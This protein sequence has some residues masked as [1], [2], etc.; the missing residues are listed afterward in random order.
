MT[1][2]AHCGGKFGA[3]SGDRIVRIGRVIAGRT[4]A[5]LALNAGKLR[6]CNLAGESRRQ[7]VPHRVAGQTT[8]ILVLMGLL[9]RFE[10]AP[11][12]RIRHRVVNLAV[13]LCAGLSAD[14]LRR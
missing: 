12:P 8:G 6:G 11:M 14:V 9:E 4:V 5:I 3:R 7:L 2:T 1:S 13:A 10:G